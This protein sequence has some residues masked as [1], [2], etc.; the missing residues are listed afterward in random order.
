M[1]RTKTPKPIWK[2]FRVVVDVTDVVTHTNFDD[3]WLSGCWVAGVKFP[4]FCRLSSSLLQHSRT[5]CTVRV[6]DLFIYLYLFHEFIYRSDPLTDFYAW[7]LKRRGL[8]QECFWGGSFILL[9]ILG[10]KCPQTP[11][12]WVVNRRFESQTGKI[13]NIPCH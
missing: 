9:P 7:W 2:K 10:V 3:H 5:T 11:N 1:R 6:C 4:L 13:L 12:F 8:A